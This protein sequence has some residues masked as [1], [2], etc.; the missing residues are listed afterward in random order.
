[1]GRRRR[2]GGSGNKEVSLAQ[3]PNKKKQIRG[4]REGITGEEMRED[5]RDER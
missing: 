1:M 3:E 5:L 2:N 4:N